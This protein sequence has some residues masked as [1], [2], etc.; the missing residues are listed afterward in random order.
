M[1][2]TAATIGHH[3]DFD[4]L[5]AASGRS[6]EEAVTALET[7]LAAGILRE[8]PSPPLVPP[9]R[10]GPAPAIIQPPALD[11]RRA[12]A[13]SDSPRYNFA[14]DKF[15][16]YVY[17][18]MSQVRRRLLHRRLATVLIQSQGGPA[19]AII[20]THLHLAGDQHQAATYYQQAGDDARSV[21]ANR[22][23]LG[24]YQAA[25]SLRHP[26]L[27]VLHEASG[28]LNMLLG[29]YV[30]ALESFEQA[31]ARTESEL[32][33]GRL[34]YKCGLLYQRKGDWN[35]SETQF[36]LASGLSG[37]SDPFATGTPWTGSGQAV[38]RVLSPGYRL[39]TTPRWSPTGADILIAWAYSC[40]RQ[41][42]ADEATRKAE[43]ALALAEE[44]SDPAALATVHNVLGILH[45]QIGRSQSAWDHL[46]QSWR[47][48]QI[49]E[50]PGLQIAALNNMALSAAAADDSDRA[51]QYAQSALD[52]ASTIGDRHLEAALHSNLAD[53][54]HRRGEEEPARAHLRRSATIYAEIG[55]SGEDWQPEIWKLTEW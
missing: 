4:L 19:A 32:D 55:R 27:S 5:L 41:G 18:E 30:A 26:D 1:L 31:M 39:P 48:A 38:S 20:A 47:Q 21:Y 25:I 2:Q 45:R 12:P 3:F 54:L 28:D 9:E 22:E 7:L 14:H 34:A 13:R 10:T 36:A 37:R 50:R 6:D 33:R 49:S 29:E 11:P 17:E 42:R 44:G 15:R 40:Q 16:Q 53:L 23:A 8:V 51:L 35:A 43:Q 52:L 24:H 46:Q